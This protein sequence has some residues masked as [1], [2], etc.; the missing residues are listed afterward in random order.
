MSR[1]TEITER[2]RHPAGGG[3]ARGDEVR[4]RIIRVAIEAFGLHGYEGASTRAIAEMASVNAPV[5]QYYFGGKQG[6]YSACADH[7]V[8]I[9]AA[10]L[11]AS[12]ADARH[13][14]A[15][16]KFTK[17]AALMQLH[18][19]LSEILD[20][21]LASEIE[22][23]PLFILREQAHPTAAFDSVYDKIM[24]PVI[25]TCA[26]LIARLSDLSETDPQ[27]ALAALGLY[28]QITSFRFGR[29]AVL[30]ALGTRELT[31]AHRALIK[32]GLLCQLTALMR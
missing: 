27:A 24:G 26:A 10:R 25:Q 13:A 11:A 23:W 8:A 29:E 15:S 22:T 5:L 21:L 32:A 4:S 30:R 17:N 28:G 20:M 31:E 18:R 2:R 14:L 9:I 16:R 12:L 6:L 19:L 3:Y 1:K 7:I